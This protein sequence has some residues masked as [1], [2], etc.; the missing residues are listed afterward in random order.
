MPGHS[1]PLND[2]AVVLEALA[3]HIDRELG[4]HVPAKH[5]ARE[6]A[7]GIREVAKAAR[8]IARGEVDE[9]GIF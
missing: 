4:A 5:V 2:L 1:S 8:A 6:A 7:A 3:G 9:H